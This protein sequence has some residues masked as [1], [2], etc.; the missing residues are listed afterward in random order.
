MDRPKWH[1]WIFTGINVVAIALVLYLS[2]RFTQAPKQVAYSEFLTELRA[3]NLTDVQIT[4]RELIGV[5]KSD[6]SHP[7]P[8]QELTIKATRLPGVDESLLLKELESH[9]I[10]FRGHI[11]QGS[12]FWNVLGFLFP[13]LFI[14]LIYGVGMRRIAQGSGPLTFGKNRAKIHDESSRMQVTFEDVAGVDE[15]K[16]ELEEVVDFLRQPAKYQKLGGRIPK[17]VLLV[18]PPGTGKTLLAKAVAGEARV[19]FFSISGSEFVEMFVGVG[20][21][22]VRDLFEQ[23]KQKAPCIVFIDELDAIGK[24]RSSGRA[25]GFSN[26]EREQ[27]LNQLLAEIDGFDTSEGVIIMA[28]TNTPEVLDPALLRAG[29][30]DRQVLVDRPDLKDRVEILKVHAKK[31]LMAEN[32]VLDTIASRTPGM[33]GADLANII[34]EAA[35]LAVR[36]GGDRV[37]MHDLEEAVDRVMLGLEKKSR[38]MSPEEK[39]RV[40]VHE[41]GHAL[42]ALSVKH[43][44]PLHRVSIIPRSIGALG[45][46]LQLPT[47][48]RYLMTQPELED[49]IAVLLGGRTAEEIH[50]GGVV[51]TGAADDLERASALVRQMVTR[52]G[53]SDLLGPLTYGRPMAA[54]FLKSPFDMEERNYSEQTAERI[55]D[56][57]RRIVDDIRKRVT[58]ILSTRRAPMERISRELIR[59]ETLERA[60]LDK[61]V[62]VC[63]PEMVT[64]ASPIEVA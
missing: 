32:V 29:R 42:V 36:H 46:T 27:T 61:L 37:E 9:P 7:K 45:Y 6:A 60:E 15:A 57:S 4:E 5:L 8:I 24:A 63:Q 13:L 52:F 10:K 34:N 26:D 16:L 28:A 1:R 23:A 49:Q 2:S 11:D 62:A 30:F 55:D 31:I 14:A 3:G 54:Q 48:E 21:A 58:G 19:S 56:E 64:K 43:A 51:S 50:Y 47:Q 44:D 41:A 33:V 59:K 40:A 38:V 53:M 35:L 12:W 39:E 25:I 22:R 20:A 18:G 17:G